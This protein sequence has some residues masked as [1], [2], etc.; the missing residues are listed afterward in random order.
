MPRFNPD[1][2]ARTYTVTLSLSHAE[3]LQD[4]LE[5]AERQ[6]SIERDRAF[7]AFLLEGGEALEA[8]LNYAIK[9][10]GAVT[11]LRREVGRHI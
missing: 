3:A 1:P 4:A 5:A 6:A 8:D 9:R 11:Q 10:L 2:D 7:A